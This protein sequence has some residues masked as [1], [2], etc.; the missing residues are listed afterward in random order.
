VEAAQLAISTILGAR[1]RTIDIDDVILN[2]AGMVVGWF[3]V[4]AALG[5]RSRRTAVARQAVATN[6]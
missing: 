1:Y 3:V 6:R 4:R 5:S 2:A